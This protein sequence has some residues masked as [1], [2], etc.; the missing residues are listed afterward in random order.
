MAKK[1]MAIGL[2]IQTNCGSF[3]MVKKLAKNCK[4]KEEMQG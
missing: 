1:R 2:S 3:E 4:G